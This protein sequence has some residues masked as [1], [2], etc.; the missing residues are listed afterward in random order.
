M[1][2][3]DP[4]YFKCTLGSVVMKTI[5]LSNT[6]KEPILYFVKLE[7]STDFSIEEDQVKIEPGSKYNYNIKFTSRISDE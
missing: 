4:L 5:T 6:T 3:R 7:G 2:R 1:P